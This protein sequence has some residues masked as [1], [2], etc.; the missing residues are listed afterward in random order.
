LKLALHPD[1]SKILSVSRGVEFLG[2]RL[3]PHH[4][5]LKTKN[6]RKCNRKLAAFSQEYSTGRLTYD[7]IYEF[8]EGWLLMLGMQTPTMYEREY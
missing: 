7:P 4:K 6:M 3:F 2:M 8:M 1:K 5:L